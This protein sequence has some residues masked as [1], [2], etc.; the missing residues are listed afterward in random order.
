MKAFCRNIQL[1]DIQ[2]LICLMLSF[3]G[4]Q[5]LSEELNCNWLEVANSIIGPITI[6]CWI[7]GVRYKFVHKPKP[8]KQPID[9]ELILALQNLGYNKKEC[10]NLASKAKGDTLEQQIKTAL[11]EK[12]DP[13]H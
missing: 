5:Y 1:T 8:F 7:I 2:L 12:Y 10:I 11:K 9:S 6:I 4:I 13:N 3:C